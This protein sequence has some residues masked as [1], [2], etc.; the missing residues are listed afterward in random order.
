MAERARSEHDASVRSAWSLLRRNRDFRKL[1]TAS[2][3]SFGGDWFLFV[4]LGG[5]IIEVTGRATNVALLIE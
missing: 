4:A 3:I 5:L 2:I 1:Y